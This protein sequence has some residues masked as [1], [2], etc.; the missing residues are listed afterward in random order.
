MGLAQLHQLKLDLCTA[1]ATKTF[2]IQSGFKPVPAN[3]AE[4]GCAAL[5]QIR[6]IQMCHCVLSQV[7]LW[8]LIMY[9][10]VSARNIFF[11]HY[12]EMSCV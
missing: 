10:R 9:G 3:S 5:S 2:L 6:G 11:L 12:Q 1:M 7:I 8:Y 4:N